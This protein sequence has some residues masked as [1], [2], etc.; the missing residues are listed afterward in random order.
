MEVGFHSFLYYTDAPVSR[1][2]FRIA[3]SIVVGTVALALVI[4]GYFGWRFYTYPQRAHDGSGEKKKIVIPKG[5]KVRD[6]ARLLVSAGVIERPRWFAFHASRFG[7]RIQ[8][9]TYLVADN[10]TPEEVMQTLSFPPAVPLEEVK[11]VTFILREGKNLLDLAAA[12]VKAKLAASP[13]EVLAAA[14]DPEVIARLG[15]PKGTPSLEGYLFPDTYRVRPGTP[16]EKVFTK[17]IDRFHTVYEEEALKHKAS[18]DKVKLEFGWTDHEVVLMASLVEKETAAPDERPRIAAVFMNRLRDP[19]FKPKLLQ[20]DP[21]I[22]YGCV[23]LPVKSKACEKFEDRIRRAQLDDPDNPYNTYTH[24]GMPPGPIANAGRLALAAV[25]APE[26]SG[27]L[28]FVSKNDGTHVFSK[29]RAEHE[30]AVDKYQRRKSTSPEP[31]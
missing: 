14:R 15:L 8:P 5:A 17:M 11:D 23:A 2:S 29:T 3:L 13:E 31:N 9:G 18:L 12:L 25:M 24:E 7:L 27:Y 20:T 4:G 30:A 19:A 10:L 1:R 6:A 21:T 28:Y 26:G 22:V 16:L